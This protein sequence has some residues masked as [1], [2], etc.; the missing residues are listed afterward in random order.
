[1]V[2]S[3]RETVIL[4]GGVTGLAAAIASGRSAFEAR[5]VPGGICSSYYV[6]P[7]DGTR[8]NDAPEDGEA[9]RFEIGGGHWL[10]GGDPVVLDLIA[11]LTPVRSYARRSSVYFMHEG[12]MVPYPLQN[13]LRFLNGDLAAK[14]LKEIASPPRTP[15]RTMAGWLE[16]SFGKTLTEYFFG[17]FHDLYTDGLWTRIAPQDLYKSP[18]DIPRV[19]KGARRETSSVGYNTT[20]V[21]PTDGLGALVRQMAARSHMRFG[22]RAERIDL[23]RREVQFSDGSGSRYEKIISTLPLNQAIEIAGLSTESEPDPH[24]SV[25]VLNIGARRGPR[26]PDDHWLYVPDSLSGFY[27]IGFY[28]NVDSSFLPASAR[29]QNDSVSLYVERAFQGGRRPSEAKIQSYTEG[30]LKELRGCGF[31]TKCEVVDPTWVGVAYTWSWPGSSWKAEAL[32]LLQ[33]NNIYQVGRYARWK[34]DGIANSVRDGLVAGAAL[35]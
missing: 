15:A 3:N 4:G 11:S 23:R 28:S 35:R 8:L 29:A 17:P 14:A 26:C 20:Y 16:Q 1:M 6:R 22:S 33:E 10:F 25:L 31:I 34:F 21:Y 13:H 24:T 12:L 32:E 27:R 19:I 7:Q 9:Y 18:V 2:V 5:D 30:V